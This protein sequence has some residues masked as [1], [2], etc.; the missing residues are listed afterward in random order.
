MIKIPKLWKHQ[1]ETM[2]LAKKQ[3]GILDTSDPGTGKTRAHIESFVARNT[4]KRMLVVCPKTLMQTAWG[5]DIET[6]APKLTT[7]FAHAGKRLDAFTID[8]DVVVINTDGVR[9]LI[10]KPFEKVLKEF[11]T[12][13]IDEFTA[14]KNPQA[15][16]TKAMIKLS[17]QFTYTAQ[18][19]GTPNPN[20]VMELFVP[21]LILDKG[22]RLGTSYTALRAKVQI[23]VQVGPSANMIRWDDSPGAAIAVNQIISDVTIRHVF[24]DVMAHVPANHRNT[25]QFVLPP[26]AMKQYMAM[27]DT[28][29]LEYDDGDVNAVH[30]ASLRNKLLQIA[31]GAV[32]TGNEDS[33][34]I[35][36]DRTRY[37]LVADIVESIDH[38]VVFFNWK[39]QRDLLIESFEKRGIT[40]ALIDGSVKDTKRPNIVK[41]YQAGEYQT[42]LLHPRTGAHGLTLTRGTTTI[43]CSPIYEADMLKQGIHRIYRGGQTKVTN[44]IMIE[45]KHTVERKVYERLDTKYGRMVDLLEMMA[46]N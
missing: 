15:E 23:P 5:N 22:Q 35:V 45:A 41:K 37:E 21:M 44:T 3:K 2:A 11:D 16:R 32:Y 12:L 10:T 40:Y 43:I 13:V 30:A 28:C 17:K 7:A 42:L 20:T 46:R 29:R 19:S 39:H 33:E 14:F 26:A 8:A 36:I 31:S 6:F 9:D 34:Y 27:E 24:E 4:G 18:L 25:K 1:I 38:S